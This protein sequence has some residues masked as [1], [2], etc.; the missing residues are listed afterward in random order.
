[1]NVRLNTLTSACLIAV[2]FFSMAPFGA[3]ADTHYPIIE[4]SPIITFDTGGDS[5]PPSG[6]VGELPPENG[7]F[8]SGGINLNGS[9]TLPITKKIAFTYA[10]YSGNGGANTYSGSIGLPSGETL[11]PGGVR[12]FFQNYELTEKAG[13]FTFAEGLATRARICCPNVADKVT[14][15]GLNSGEWHIGT[16]GV[17]WASPPL[18]FL[19]GTVFVLNET[20]KTQRRNPSPE[21][22]AAQGSYNIA[23]KGQRRIYVTTQTA[24]AVVPIDARN[25]FSVA[26]TYVWGYLNFFQNAPFPWQYGAWILTATKRVTKDIDFVL[27]AENYAQRL[28]GNPFGTPTSAIHSVAADAYLNVRIDFTRIFQAP[29]QQPRPTQPGAPGGP[30]PAQGGPAQTGTGTPAPS[31]SGSPSAPA[32]PAASAT[33]QTSPT[34]STS[35]IPTPA[36]KR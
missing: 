25:G 32:A 8:G 2:L 5:I 36:P 9:V 35:A 1:M 18:K 4:L 22:L 12:D 15:N 10:R 24:T 28:Q 33:P 20:L 26:G 34:A 30:G 6:R 27:K 29:V 17:T 7:S 3:L 16:L 14:A 31:A 21:V 23:Y 13:S 11:Y 19:N